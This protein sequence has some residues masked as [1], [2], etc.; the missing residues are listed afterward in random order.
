MPL[1]PLVSCGAGVE[2]RRPVP[3]ALPLATVLL[4]GADGCSRHSSDED[5]DDDDI[6]TPRKRRAGD[7]PKF[8]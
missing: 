2:P 6:C 3:E 1:A 7:Q 5:D 4:Q 8:H